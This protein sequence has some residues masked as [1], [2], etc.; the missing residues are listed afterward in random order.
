MSGSA[1][2]VTFSPYYVG[3]VPLLLVND[4]DL[5]LEFRQDSK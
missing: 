1:N 2:V 3:S 5:T 4:T